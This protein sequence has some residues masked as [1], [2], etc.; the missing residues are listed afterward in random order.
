MT[1][2]TLTVVRMSQIIQNSY[3]LFKAVRFR[4]K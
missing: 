2:M 1:D 4:G 3:L